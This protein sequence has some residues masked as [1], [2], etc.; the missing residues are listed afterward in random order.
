MKNQKNSKSRL[1]WLL[2]GALLA[3]LCFAIW[4][5]RHDLGDALEVASGVSPLWIAGG[6]S[7]M[8][9]SVAL[10]SGVYHVIS[11]KRLTYP[12]T[13]LV[14]MSGLF[15]NKILP[16]GS[17]GLGLSYLYLRTNKLDKLTALSVVALNNAIGFAG[18][19]LLLALVLLVDR[20]D[21]RT[22]A[23]SLP[24]NVERYLFAALA[25]V[26]SGIVVYLVVRRKRGGVQ[27]KVSGQMRQLGRA[28]R[29]PRRAAAAI[30]ISMLLTTCYV[31]CVAL[32]SS[33]LGLELS[34]PTLIIVLSVSVFATAVIPSPGGIGAAEAGMF[35][36]LRAY[37]TPAS[38][39]LAVAL[40]YRTMTFW[41]PL[42]VGVV[43]FFIME[44]LKLVRYKL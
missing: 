32:S 17:G 23:I 43:A 36:A 34:I 29:T 19:A 6:V 40:L 8:I 21:V 16:S 22:P 28:L 44:K 18:H 33:A 37:E 13:M 10:T 12:H 39:A 3:L 15:V 42:L 27:R 7:L 30:G 35:L 4:Q 31:G 25:V 26:A 2:Y 5:L 9:V 1:R 20:R 11:P 14:Q 38:T 41:L 24:D